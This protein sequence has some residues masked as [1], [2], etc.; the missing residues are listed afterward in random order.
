ME[1]TAAA[2]R[3]RRRRLDRRRRPDA[4][5]RASPAQVRRERARSA[6]RAATREIVIWNNASTD[7]T[8][9]YPRHARR[10]AHHASSTARRTSARTPTPQA[11]ALTTRRTWSSSTTTSSTRR[12]IGT[13][14]CSTRSRALPQ[15]GFLA[16]DLEDDPHD[17]ASHV[18]HHGRPRR[19]HA[20]RGERRPAALRA[21]RR[22]LRDHLARAATTASAAFASTRRSLLA[23]GRGVHHGHRAARDSAPRVSRTSA[24]TTRAAPYY[25]S[26][27]KEKADF[28]DVYWKKRL[29]GQR[30]SAC[31]PR[32]VLP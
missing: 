18:R 9:D 15:I 14:R 8:A 30:S 28:W 10:S 19:V 6:P 21:D 2:T 31:L 17:V 23:R 22:R 20:R 26:E 4:Q 29:G 32:P 5:P 7:G 24:S 11:F 16:A 12:R 3:A 13:R 1:S 25:S 27:S